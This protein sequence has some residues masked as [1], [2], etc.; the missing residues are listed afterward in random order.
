MLLLLAASLLWAFS[1]GLI[2]TQLAGL[3]PVLV[4]CGR[5]LLALLVFAPL[6]WRRRLPRRVMGRAMV[7]GVVQFGL[8]YVLYLASFAWLP[9]WKVAFFTIFTPLY[10]V[11][12]A[13]LAGRRFSPRHLL[14]ALAAVAGAALVVR[15]GNGVGDWRGV[16]LLQGANLCFAWGQLRF[17]RLCE[18][19]GGAEAALVG[20]M[21]AGAFG[22]TLLAMIVTSP[23]SLWSVGS[24][25][26]DARLAL[27]YLGVVPTG[28]GFYLW[29]RGAARTSPGLLAAANNLKVPLAI[30]VAW[31]VFRE[32]APLVRAGAGLLV[33]GLGLWLADRDRSR[34]R[35]DQ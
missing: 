3:N 10:V 9:A 25:T 29:N 6:M 1:F 24:W 26:P 7:L 2:K 16:L 12:L 21:Y 30:L 33:I 13:D 27:L 35:V 19:A 22:V 34:K 32:E 31:A 23:A 11:G 4:A 17:G 14:A 5:L 8:M 28:L 20:W 18:V 15:N